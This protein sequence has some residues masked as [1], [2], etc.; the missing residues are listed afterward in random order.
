MENIAVTVFN[1]ALIA[2]NLASRSP[3]YQA[4]VRAALYFRFDGQSIHFPYEQ[5]FA[6]FDAFRAGV[7]H[8]HALWLEYCERRG[9]LL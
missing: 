2:H 1:R 9:I 4:G 5:G 3:E 6:S 7:D 8:G